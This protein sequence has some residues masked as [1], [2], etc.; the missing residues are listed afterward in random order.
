MAWFLKENLLEEKYKRLNELQA[1]STGAIGLVTST[2]N[3]LGTVN[4]E[5]DV[6]I[7]EINE[8]KAQLSNTEEELNLVKEKNTRVITNFRR[9]IEE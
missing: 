2:I 1:K 4:E 9:L 6:V 5:I 7:S 8:A 3:S